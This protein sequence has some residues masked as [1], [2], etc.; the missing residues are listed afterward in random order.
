MSYRPSL[1]EKMESSYSYGEPYSLAPLN[2]NSTAAG[3]STAFAKLVDGITVWGT[4]AFWLGKT[5]TA[6]GTVADGSGGV[7][8]HRI[9]V[10]PNETVRF[11]W[12]TRALWVKQGATAGSV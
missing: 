9:K 4:K 6:V 2:A 5:S 3:S 8:K 10:N 7:N 12:K 1:E 11:S